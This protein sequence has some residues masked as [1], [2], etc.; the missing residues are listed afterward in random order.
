MSP[1]EGR[2]L[3][4][5]EDRPLRLSLDLIVFVAD[6]LAR[7]ERR[8]GTAARLL[9]QSVARVTTQLGRLQLVVSVGMLNRLRS[10]LERRLGVTATTVEA[11]VGALSRSAR[12][13][14]GGQS[15]LLV[16][17]GTGVLPMPDRED[18]HVLETAVAGRAD[19]LATADMSDFDFPDTIV[20]EEGRVL[21]YRRADHDV[22]I[23]HPFRAAR[24][25]REGRILLPE[26]P[27]RERGSG[28]TP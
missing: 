7:R 6:L 26:P 21:R 14:P 27:S 11:Y 16:L 5:P 9:V 10:V 15:P 17:G 20:L 19:L 3:T 8:E 22:V 1:D 23:A 12:F 4:P 2:E 24:W 25:I 18:A 28:R 13:G